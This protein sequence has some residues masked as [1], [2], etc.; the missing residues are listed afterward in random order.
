MIFFPDTANSDEIRE[1]MSPVMVGG[2]VIVERRL[3][4][5]CAARSPTRPSAHVG[6][7]RP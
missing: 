5:G 2:R 1:E 7:R 3:G 6:R 4:N